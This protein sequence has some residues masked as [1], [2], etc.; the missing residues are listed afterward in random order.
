MVVLKGGRYTYVSA[1]AASGE[2]RSIDV[3][4]FYDV[5]NYRPKVRT[6]EDMPMYL[7]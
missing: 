2:A 5:E 6:V 3:E 7:Y 4:A 1:S